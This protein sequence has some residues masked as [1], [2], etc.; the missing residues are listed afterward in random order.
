MFGPN[1]T[2]DQLRNIVDEMS[3]LDFARRVYCQEMAGSYIAVGLFEDVLISAMHMCD[4]V[5][6]KQI[7]GDDIDRWTQSPAK[8]TQLQGSTLGSLIKIL[9]GHAI[10]EADIRY[11]KW[12]KDKR[13]YFV[14]RLFHE[15]A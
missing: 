5:K 2:N 11:L 14:H 13:D 12:I 4:R 3:D 15:G 8:K 10:A 7:L 1:L 9:E 6:L